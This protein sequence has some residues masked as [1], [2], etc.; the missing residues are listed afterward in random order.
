MRTRLAVSA[1][2][3]T[4]VALGFAGCKKKSPTGPDPVPH[5]QTPP[6]PPPA[7]LS[8]SV[9]APYLAQTINDVFEQSLRQG[10]A[11]TG[12]GRW[13]H[14]CPTGGTVRTELPD[15]YQVQA[16]EVVML[17]D[18]GI[19][20]TDCGIETNV[21]TLE[22]RSFVSRL[23]DVIVSPLSAQSRARIVARGRLRG[24]GKW[25]PPRIT[26]SGPEYRDA[27]V[28]LSG[29][30]EV[31]QINCGGQPCPTQ[32]GS[33]RLECNVNG[34][35]CQGPI[36]TIIIGPRDT[37]PPPNPP[38]TPPPPTQPPT[39]PGP[40]PGPPPSSINV[41]GTWTVTEIG[42]SG[43]GT[44]TLT[45]SGSTITGGS[46]VVPPIPGANITTNRFTGSVSGSAVNLVHSF[47]TRI[48]AGGYTTTCTS[49]TNYALQASSNNR[50]SGPFSG[51]ARCVHNI[52]E[53]PQPPT[54]TYSGSST[55]TR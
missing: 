21:T 2:L 31:S 28:R 55:W 6:N 19:L 4:A 7:P 45:Q 1:L 42:Q 33:I 29:D 27:P 44:A 38:P 39:P 24:K 54:Q 20:F 49:T 46:A 36:G 26:S 17:E 11:R 18:T 40:P 16:G 37:P 10:L 13:T 34:V 25:R 9:V 51:N 52:P 8:L 50:M 48:D 47:V 53:V 32:I 3:I 41:T 35:V 30:L 14:P 15:N 12:S 22:S 23:M 43:A 5:N